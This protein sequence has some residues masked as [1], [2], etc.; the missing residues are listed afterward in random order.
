MSQAISTIESGPHAIIERAVLAGD[1]AKLSAADRLNYY[2]AVCESL[3]LNPLTRPFEY[4]TLNGKLTLYARKDATEQLRKLHGIS[5]SITNRE[6]IGDAYVVTARATTKDGR[7]DESIGAVPAGKLGGG[8]AMC[9]AIMKAETKAKRRVTLSICGLGIFDEMEVAAIP[10]AMIEQLPAAA[11]DQDV[12][13]RLRELWLAAG[14][15]A[16]EWDGYYEKTLASKTVEQRERTAQVW[17]QS[18]KLKVDEGSTESSNGDTDDGWQIPKA[19]RLIIFD[20]CHKLEKMGVQ[21]NEWRRKLEQIS[22]ARSRKQLTPDTAAKVAFA[23]GNWCDQ[24]EQGTMVPKH[25]KE[26]KVKA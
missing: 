24:V 6:Q 22:G 26:S 16:D 3:G 1:L 23:F 8:E 20:L 7:S 2:T 13:A 14:R 5:V 10:G 9:N 18:L 25:A 12:D 17:E 21:E 19:D 15:S 11:N 4:I